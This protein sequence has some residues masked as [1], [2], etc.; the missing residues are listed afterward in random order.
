MEL[1]E[2]VLGKKPNKK[3]VEK[4]TRNL[5]AVLAKADSKL[6][7]CSDQK[8]VER[9]RVN[10]IKNKLGFTD[11]E[12]AR[13]VLEDVCQKTKEAKVKDRLVFYY[14]VI[15]QLKAIKKYLGE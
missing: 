4:L 3:L 7:A 6:V 2:K 11:I 10:L 5:A 9:V 15:V 1:L 13:K 14:L 8:E 12:K